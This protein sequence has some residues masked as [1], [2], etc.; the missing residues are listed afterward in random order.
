MT[1]ID[2][3]A[4][5]CYTVT[6]GHGLLA[7]TGRRLLAVHEP[8]RVLVV[9]DETVAPL[10]SDA[11]LASLASAGFA[12]ERYV[13]PPG[14]TSKSLAALGGLLE[15]LAGAGYTRGDLLCALG[16][17]VVGD[18]TGFAA[19][20][21]QR[22]VDFIQLPTT[23]LAAVDSSVGGKTAINLTAGKNLAGSFWQPLMVLC[24]CDTL[25]T[26]PRDIYADGLAEVIKY[27]VL[28][29]A[30]L[31]RMLASEQPLDEEAVIARCVAIKRD[32]VQGDEFDRGDR[33][34]L[35]LGHT[36][37]HAVERA[38]GFTVPHGRAVAIGLAMAARVSCARGL[39]DDGT[40]EQ[41]QAALA[42]HGLP[43]RSDFDA[44]TLS[45]YAAGDKKRQGDTVR[46]V[47]M[48]GI[49][50]CLLQDIPL[51]D[52]QRLFQIGCGV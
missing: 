5:K 51:A 40:V 25:G 37:G 4:S 46:F 20:V 42:R 11:A 50:D 48:R 33:A 29:D 27:G 12:A 41:I 28:A 32:Y 49:G 19:S 1:N 38:S 47:L 43:M 39:C 3:K 7:Q 15:H 44:E 16:G 22:G 8:C 13:V 24:D 9:T 23:V 14:E 45:R 10:W 18:L 31:F 34:F 35:N 52:L 36:F 17:G 2:V 21:Y 6:V 26:L 30:E